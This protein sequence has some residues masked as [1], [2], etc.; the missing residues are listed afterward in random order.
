MP[1]ARG[2]RACT[3]LDGAHA[4][5]KFVG[6]PDVSSR[7]S[8]DRGDASLV[9]ATPPR[10]RPSSAAPTIK[11]PHSKCTRVMPRHAHDMQGQNF[12]PH[13]RVCSRFPE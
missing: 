2:N 8:I 13:A 12:P 1:D 11:D 7:E 5:T 3:A 10:Q 6:Q 9:E 4:S